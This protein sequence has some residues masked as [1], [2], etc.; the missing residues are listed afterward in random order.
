MWVQE[1]FTELKNINPLSF[2]SWVLRAKSDQF[3]LIRPFESLSKYTQILLVFRCIMACLIYILLYYI[4]NSGIFP[5]GYS[6]YDQF[7]LEKNALKVDMK[8]SRKTVNL[9]SQVKNERN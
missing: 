6:R 9:G 5:G 8:F 4:S 2:Q 7:F 3:Y 1:L